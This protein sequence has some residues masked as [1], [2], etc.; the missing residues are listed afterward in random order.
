MGW[1]NLP[2]E[3]L[4]KILQEVESAYSP[5]LLQCQLTCRAWKQVS[6]V[7]LYSSLTLLTYA[8]AERAL[9]TVTTYNLNNAV[10]KVSFES[11][12]TQSPKM[13]QFLPLF[14]GACRY[15]KSIDSNCTKDESFWTK[16]LQECYKG[17]L[18]KVETLP[19][20]ELSRDSGIKIYGYVA[21][22][23]CSTLTA[24]QIW[25]WPK[26]EP[27]FRNNPVALN[28][29]KFPHLKRL[30]VCVSGVYNASKVAPLIQD[31]KQLEFL[32]IVNHPDRRTF[33][34]HTGFDISL[35]LPAPMPGIKTIETDMVTMTQNMINQL[36]HAFP[37]LTRLIVNP[38]T[39]SDFNLENDLD[40]EISF[41]VRMQLEGHSIAR[42]IW[43]E[44]IAHVYNNVR[45]FELSAIFPIDM[46]QV[47]LSAMQNPQFRDHGGM[48]RI[49]YVRR[50]N[51]M[52]IE[53][54]I[55]ISS[56]ENLIKIVYETRE[57]YNAAN[58]N[59]I[60]RLPHMDLVESVG[61]K[62]K[63][64]HV[65]INPAVHFGDE[66]RPLYSLA[67]GYFLDHVLEN[68][69][70]L[71]ELTVSGAHLIEC[72]PDYAVSN[73][74]TTLRLIEC[75]VCPSVLLQ[76]SHR[77]PQLTDFVFCYSCFVSLAGQVLQTNKSI[78]IDLSHTTLNSLSLEFLNRIYGDCA[79]FHL[80]IQRLNE[81]A[82]Y[83]GRD[84]KEFDRCKKRAYQE[85]L[86]YSHSVSIEILCVDLKSMFLET[87]HFGID[88]QFKGSN[89]FQFK[90][91]D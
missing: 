48:L 62:F 91:D 81:V 71:T 43:T 58:V 44:F 77:L 12:L 26:S 41:L 73:S 75:L 27:S 74:V 40:E 60:G 50:N 38:T 67:G 47:V 87:T 4:L 63:R 90:F 37:N 39:E 13:E 8:D 10:R 5:E 45:T 34:S 33:Y 35:P 18:T 83:T 2:Q 15:V 61:N 78:S 30:M 57:R 6:Q 88:I 72:D 66:N 85:S 89:D 25:D 14:F 16:L 69:T 68:C 84:S 42:N 80:K 1:D 64:L 32:S 86:D 54:Y 21:M 24:V 55:G 20:A 28:L 56:A 11:P 29:H 19:R 22:E 79:E 9:N 46:D 53:P 3:V 52:E 23:L 51:F 82:Y 17:T 36:M 59:G 76:L 65:S 7:L 70:E 49:V 31:C